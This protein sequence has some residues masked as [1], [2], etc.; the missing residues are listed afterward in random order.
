M[1]RSEND[2]GQGVRPGYL[3]LMMQKRRYYAVK[4][5]MDV[6]LSVLALILLLPLMGLIALI[7]ALDSPG[8]VLFT[9]RRVGLY[10][11]PIEV[12]KFRTMISGAESMVDHFSGEREEEWERRFKLEADPRVT[13]VGR[14]LRRTSLDE[15]P[16]LINVLRGEMSLVGPRP[17]TA[18]EIERFYGENRAL[19]LSVPPGMTGYWQVDADPE[20]TYEARVAM[21]LRYAR[22]ANAPWDFLILMKTAAV[23]LTGKGRT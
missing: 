7:I 11:K 15:L 14:F 2:P 4:R 6:L 17:V 1:L 19:L 22:E 13:R 9:H 5:G 20:G 8:K 16:Q 23:V 10:G 21:E 3:P 18:E 12:I